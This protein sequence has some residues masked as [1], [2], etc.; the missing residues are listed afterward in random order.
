MAS[1]R[2]WVAAREIIEGAVQY[3]VIFANE[4]QQPPGADLFVQVMGRS[5]DSEPGEIGR[6]AMWT[7][8]GAIECLI[9]AALGIGTLEA[10]QT[11]DAIVEGFRTAPESNIEWNG[12]SLD[13]AMD[14]A[15]GTFWILILSI[16][17]RSQTVITDLGG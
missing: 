12:W 14:A 4:G 11:A 9:H 3:P 8:S 1:A 2:A 7:E 6:A 10:R 16:R 15:E 5:G 17:F 13:E